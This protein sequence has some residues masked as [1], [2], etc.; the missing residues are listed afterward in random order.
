MKSIRL[1]TLQVAR[2]APLVLEDSVEE[3]RSF[4]VTQ[5]KLIDGKLAFC[6]RDG[7]PDL[8]YTV[9]G[10]DA[11]A[12]LDQKVNPESLAL[13][14]KDFKNGDSLDLVHLCCLI[15]LWGA[16]SFDYGYEVDDNLLHTLLLNLEQHRAEDG[17][18]HA[19]KGSKRS[20]VYHSFLASGAY[21]EFSRVTPKVEELVQ[22]IFEL[23]T[24]DG[25]WANEAGVQ[26]GSTPATAAAVTLCRKLGMPFGAK[27]AE[28]LTQRLH[29]QGGFAASRLAPMPDLLSTAVTLH[30][31]SELELGDTLY[32]KI[33]EP[34]LNYIDSLWVNNDGHAAFYG[35][36]ADDAL[37]CEYTYYALLALG[38]LS[39]NHSL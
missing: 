25:A 8:Y 23:K 38:H 14:L 7:E 13:Y 37:D 20:T 28:W 17:G 22:S 2:R 29:E 1:E 15:R 3:V 10:L 30:A 39:F 16:L 33:T 5:Q 26:E 32:Q 19:R 21:A 6:D 4:L 9:F 18:Y 12:A 24:S 34:C 35:H 31:L 11:M 36:W 27:V